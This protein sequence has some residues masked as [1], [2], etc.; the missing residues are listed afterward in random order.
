MGQVASLW[1][2]KAVINQIV[3]PVISN[4][5]HDL[6][7]GRCHP[8]LRIFAVVTICVT[9]SAAIQEAPGLVIITF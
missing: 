2:Y 9:L 4:G 8:A 6:E 3:N 5:A 7:D 1:H